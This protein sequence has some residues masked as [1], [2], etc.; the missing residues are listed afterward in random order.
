MGPD[1]VPVG[2]PR[3]HHRHRR[4]LRVHPR[5]AAPRARRGRLPPAHDV[6]GRGH[7]PPGA[8]GDPLG[9]G[10]LRGL[11]RRAR[12]QHRGQ[13]RLPRRATAPSA[14]TSWAPTPSATRPPPSRSRPWSASSARPS[15]S[16]ALGFSFTTSGSHS[17]GD[18]Q[19]VPSRWATNEELLALC[20]EAGRHE[21]TT[22]EG[23][24]PGCLDR[25]ADDEIELLAE[26]SAAA[27]RPAE[28][29]RAHHRQPRG[30]PR[31]PPAARPP[32]AAAE[33][34][35]RVV[36]L[37]MPVLVPMNMNFL[38]FCGIW[39]LPGWEDILRVPGRGAH[40]A[41]EGPR[42]AAPGCS[43]RPTPTRPASTGASPTGRTTSSA[44]PSPRPTQGLSNRTV[45][46]IAAERGTEPFDTL[47][48]IV[49]AD[50]LRTVLWPA[51]QDKDDADL[52]D[53]DRGLER[54][55]GH[56]R[57]LRRRRPP[58][59]HVRRHL[60]HPLPRRHDPGPQADPGGA[61]RAADHPGARRAV[62]PPRPGHPR[63]RARRPTS[64]CSTPRPSA[65]RTPTWSP[66]SPAAA[67]G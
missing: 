20:A 55:P 42:G 45:K 32:T 21:G 26:L 29:E 54:P 57:R 13:R 43:R 3:R 1:R 44:T 16:A 12:G 31:A 61:G 47:L 34:G 62:R 35:G 37:T 19:P 60:P 5:P 4:Q 14:A 49:V 17:D 64:S 52:G 7:A 9:L 23:I 59:P 38:T 10:E 11:P 41:A 28:L 63:G 40:R 65:R 8:A 15:T 46:D 33:Q 25:F 27:N 58:R 53:A 67:S 36:A 50:D 51:P 6:P 24:V 30:R 39:L 66:T 2:Q 56:D 18:G 48:D 22:L